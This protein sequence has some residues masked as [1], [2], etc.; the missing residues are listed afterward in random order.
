MTMCFQVVS[1]QI[2]KPVK[3]SFSTKQVDATQVDLVFKATITSPWHMYGL[4]I[5]E[6]GPIPTSIGFENMKGYE[7]VGKPTQSPKPEVVDDKIFNM[8]LELHGRQVTFTQRIRKTQSDSIFINGL[9]EYMTCSDMQCV[10]GDQDFSFRLKGG[11]GALAGA[12]AVGSEE[13]LAGQQ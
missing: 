7:L 12:A 9:L 3:W 5:P 13:K 4:N 8:K 1:A 11:K 6:G 2:I 10:L